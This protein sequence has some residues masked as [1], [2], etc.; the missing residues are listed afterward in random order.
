VFVRETVVRGGVAGGLRRKETDKERDREGERERDGDGVREMTVGEAEERGERDWDEDEEG[1]RESE[2][3]RERQEKEKETEK[4]RERV[5]LVD[6]PIRSA[7]R[8][9]LTSYM[10]NLREEDIY[11]MDREQI[12][13]LIMSSSSFEDNALE[14]TKVSE[15]ECV[16]FVFSV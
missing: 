12:M 1:D 5:R 15:F 8:K 2:I 6:N 10:T 9:S 11:L 14:V 7:K 16:Y 4:E 13:R 3:E